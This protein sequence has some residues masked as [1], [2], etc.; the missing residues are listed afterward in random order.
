[1]LLVT[2]NRQLLEIALDNIVRNAFKFSDDQTVTCTLQVQANSVT[3]TVRDQGIGISQEDLNHI[4]QP[5]YRGENAR[6]YSGYGIGLSLADRII[7]LHKGKIQVT[8]GLGKG[9][10]FQITLPVTQSV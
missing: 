5:F 7:A 9:S 1:S 8:S 2:G 3:I 6:T 10:V 4:F